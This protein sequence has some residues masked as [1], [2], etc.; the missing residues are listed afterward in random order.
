MLAQ[1]DQIEASALAA[2]QTVSDETSLESLAGGLPWDAA[3]RS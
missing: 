3:R 1:L 2:L